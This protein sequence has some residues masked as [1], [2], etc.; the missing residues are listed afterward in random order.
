[1]RHLR[2]EADSAEKAGTWGRAG[3]GREHEAL[4]VRGGERG[5]GGDL[6]GERGG[7]CD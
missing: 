7:A 6:G 1:M 3:R 2:S 5:E 4:E